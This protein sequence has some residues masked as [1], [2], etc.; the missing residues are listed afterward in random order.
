[1]RLDRFNS[2]P[3][4][5]MIAVA[6]PAQA[7][8]AGWGGSSWDT[9][10]WG[11]SWDGPRASGRTRNGDG[12]PEGHV[13][14]SRFVSEGM[15]ADALARGAIS[16]VGAPTGSG[17]ESRE[18]AAYEAAVIDQLAQLGYRTDTPA[19]QTTQVT[20]LHIGHEVVV[21]P[22]A[23]RS[24]VSGEMAVGV[25][26]HG[27]MVGMAV[28]VDMTKPRGALIATRL[29]ARIRDKASGTVL[30]EGRADINTREGDDKWS[31]AKIAT[32]LAAALFDHFPGATDI[33]RTPTH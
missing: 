7:H 25:S 32:R 29:E 27:S 3:L 5:L 8:P 18:L 26:N 15:G 24:P 19:A 23:R 21:P 22:E 31:D 20:E 13:A 10:R 1:M 33:D 4:L 16:V 6:G 14:V 28:N 17:V 12:P 2:V 9:E 30:W 11:A